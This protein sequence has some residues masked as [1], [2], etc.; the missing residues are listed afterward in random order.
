MITRSM[1]GSTTCKF[2]L[3]LTYT[4]NGNTMNIRLSP[5]PMTNLSECLYIHYR[6]VFILL[7]PQYFLK[8]LFNLLKPST[9][10]TFRPS[11]KNSFT[12]RSTVE[13]HSSSFV[14]FHHPFRKV[15]LFA[16]HV[17]GAPCPLPCINS[18][19]SFCFHRTDEVR[20]T[21]RP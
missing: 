12:V 14:C 11:Q 20:F 3:F 1:T 5:L 13:S 9:P 18:L 6:F 7:I 19:I 4:E 10:N 21:S 8:V 17:S 2:S 15:R 16:T